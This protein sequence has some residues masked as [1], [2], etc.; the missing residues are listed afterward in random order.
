[1]TSGA[2]LRRWSRSQR[3]E[4]PMGR[5]KRPARN[6][7]PL[8]RQWLCGSFNAASRARGATGRLPHVH[9]RL[10][11]GPT[12]SLHSRDRQRGGNTPPCTS[13]RTRAGRTAEI[14]LS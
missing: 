10:R 14:G 5:S 12:G 8:T 6:L 3:F 9:G 4:N 1:V 2:R 7:E 13:C 11:L